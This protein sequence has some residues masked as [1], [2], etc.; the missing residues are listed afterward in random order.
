MSRSMKE[1]AKKGFANFGKKKP[2]KEDSKNKKIPRT[3]NLEE[4][5]IQ[6]VEIIHALLN[7]ESLQRQEIVGKAIDF[8]WEEEYKEKY[9]EIKEIK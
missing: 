9:E 5:Q 2:K 4:S 1:D 3:Y 7:K 6:K 8:L